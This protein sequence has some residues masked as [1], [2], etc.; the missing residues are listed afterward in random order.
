MTI[1]I[2]VEYLRSSADYKYGWEASETQANGHD[3]QERAVLS[4]LSTLLG[5]CLQVGLYG[6][7]SRLFLAAQVI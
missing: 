5:S 4:T 2:R 3:G 7:T 6:R 1:S